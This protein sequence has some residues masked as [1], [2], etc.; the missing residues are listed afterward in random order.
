MRR[1]EGEARPAVLKAQDTVAGLT[2]EV[3]Q[4]VLFSTVDVGGAC[5]L[6]HGRRPVNALHHAAARVV[7]TAIAVGTALSCGAMLH[8]KLRTPQGK[9]P[10]ESRLSGGSTR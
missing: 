7:A 1:R 8:E 2:A 9:L 4:A 3:R 10:L 5:S 6:R